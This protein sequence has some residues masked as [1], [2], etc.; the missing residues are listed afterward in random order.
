MIR[1]VAYEVVIKERAVEDLDAMRVYDAA[2]VVA[3]IRQQLTIEP[4]VE[5]RNRK[6][7]PGF[8]PR[9]EHELPVWELRV[10]ERRVFYSVDEPARVVHVWAVIVKGRKT[11]GELS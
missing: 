7:L 10:G 4:T 11:S 2:R 6:L 5:T 9:F 8:V 1:P 3:A